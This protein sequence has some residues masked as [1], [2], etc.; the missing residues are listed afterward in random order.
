MGGGQPLDFNGAHKQ[1]VLSGTVR[2]GPK[3]R[4]NLEGRMLA[5]IAKYTHI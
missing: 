3:D 5:P 2:I 4:G 1:A